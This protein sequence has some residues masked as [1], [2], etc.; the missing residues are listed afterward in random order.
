MMAVQDSTLDLKT[1][2]SMYL[3]D[4][5]IN[6]CFESYPQ[7]KI[8]L[9]MLL[10]HTAGFT[11]EAP[12]GNNYDYCKVSFQEHLNSIPDTWLKFPAGTKYS[13]SNLGYDLAAQIIEVACEKSFDDYLSEKVFIPLEMYSTTVNDDKVVS[14]I[15]RTEGVIPF[16]K[17]SHNAIPMVGAGGVYTNLE[18]L[19]KYTQFHMNLG[20]AGEE[21]VL[22]QQYLYEMYRI[23]SRNCGLGTYMS[24]SQDNYFI[25]HN[26]GGY[27]FTSTLFLMPEHNLGVVLLCNEDALTFEF[28]EFIMNSYIE[29]TGSKRNAAITELFDSLNN[30]YFEEPEAFNRSEY[31]SCNG[32]TVFQE[33]WEVY[34]GTYAIMYPGYNPKWYTKL[35][36]NLGYRPQKIEILNSNNKLVF[37]GDL[38]ESSLREIRK[39]IFISEDGEIMDF[40]K[41]IPTYRNIKLE[42]R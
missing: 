14:N 29:K 13:Y 19:T 9:E 37:K 28:C 15:N 36:F 18:D 38:G 16:L 17:T 32:E 4:F 24:K 42:K 3:P 8:T 27:G 20:R 5:T 30:D 6:S 25:N 31:Y 7:D 22:D 2:I 11:H 33:K 39:G 34:T 41:E 10:S 35:A 12:A 1:P 40:S 23:R 21:Q 26:G